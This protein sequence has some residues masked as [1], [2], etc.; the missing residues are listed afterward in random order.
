MA[1]PPPWPLAGVPQDPVT[2]PRLPRVNV[3]GRLIKWTAPSP[4]VGRGD[5]A[6]VRRAVRAPAH[7]VRIT[8]AGAP[9]AGRGLAA[10]PQRHG[11]GTRPDLRLRLRPEGCGV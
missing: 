5:S 10:G 11:N 1:W 6:E 7:R 4:Q 2:C 3:D 8:G 9:G